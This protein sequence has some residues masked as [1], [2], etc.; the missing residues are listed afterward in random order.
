MSGQSGY[1]LLQYLTLTSE[2]S[3][4]TVRILGVENMEGVLPDALH[5]ETLD[6]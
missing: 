1:W 3:V 4:E 5:G 2:L 6:A